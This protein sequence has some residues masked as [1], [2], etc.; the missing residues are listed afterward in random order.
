[1]L[2]MLA[3]SG[4]ERFFGLRPQNDSVVSC[5]LMLGGNPERSRETHKAT[6]EFEEMNMVKIP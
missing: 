2:V 3:D 6:C 4:L 1:M 5:F